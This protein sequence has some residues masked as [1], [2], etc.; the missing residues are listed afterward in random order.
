MLAN[1]EGLQAGNE[2]I[3]SVSPGDN[4]RWLVPQQP[5]LVHSN[6]DGCKA[7][8]EP[9]LEYDRLISTGENFLRKQLNLVRKLLVAHDALD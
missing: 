3:Y 6:T 1:V 9:G 2:D 7:I 4:L 5:G 8:L